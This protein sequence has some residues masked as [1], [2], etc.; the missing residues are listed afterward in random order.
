[1]L[2]DYGL[3]CQGA[4]KT[5]QIVWMV[6]LQE[7]P[8]EIFRYN[9]SSSIA[10]LAYGI[11]TVKNESILPEYDLNLTVL[12]TNCSS[13]QGIGVLV[14]L[15]MVQDIDVVIG[16]P[17]P[18]VVEPVGELMS[19][20]NV[21]VINWVSLQQTI[22]TK[23][24]LT[25]YIRTMTPV[26]TL[27]ELMT[28]F[29][30]DTGWK[31]YII[32]RE[33]N[34]EYD[35]LAEILESTL[36]SFNEIGFRVTQVHKL[37]EPTESGDDI[38]ATLNSIKHEGRIVFLVIDQPNLRN[39]M[40]RAHKL[41]MTN[42]D[43]QFLYTYGRTATMHKLEKYFMNDRMW[44]RNDEFDE[45]ARQAFENVL[46]FTLSQ[47]TEPESKWYGYAL[48]SYNHLY[49]KT[50][51][52]R[53]L[54]VPDEYAVYLYDAVYLYA[55]VLNQ[56]LTQ[57]RTSSGNDLTQT[58]FH[59]QIGFQGLTGSV[60]ISNSR[61]DRMPAFFVLDMDANGSFHVVT[62]LYYRSSSA[63]EL[64]MQ[65]DNT[66][67][68]WGN[69]RESS[70]LLANGTK[71][72]Y[73]PPD[74]PECGLLN[75]KCPPSPPIIA[76]Q[77]NSYEVTISVI[78]AAVLIL[79]FAAFFVYRWWRKEQDLKNTAWKIN[80]SDLRYVPKEDQ[81]GSQTGP[82]RRIHRLRSTS[83]IESVVSSS[84]RIMSLVRHHSDHHAHV[85]TNVAECQGVTVA[86]KK[87]RKKKVNIDRNFML[88]MKN[89]SS[90]KHMNVTAFIGVCTEPEKVCIVWEFCSKGSVQDVI[91]NENINLDTMFKLS[92]ANDICQ[93]LEYIHKSVIKY[94]GNLKS[95]NCVI[96]SRWVCKLTDF[97]LQ[98]LRH[99][100]ETA[101][102]LG[103]VVYYSRLFWTAP[104]KLRKILR[105]EPAEDSVAADIYSLGII[106]KELVCRNEPY[107]LETMTLSPKE[108]IKKV[109]L[110][111]STL[112]TY[113]PEITLV[114]NDT[115]NLVANTR[116][117]IKKCWA[118]KEEMRPPLKQ[119]IRT[120]NR[121]NPFKKA[122]MVDNMMAMMEKYTNNLEEIVAERTE[123]LQDEK[124]KTDALLYRMLPKKVADD[125][126]F[127]K[128][129]L[130]EAFDSVT[131]YLS[132]IVQFTNLAN[133]STPMEIVNLLN[134]LYTLFDES[135]NPYD[136]YK[137]ETIGDAYMV[138]SG[139]P[140]RNGS[141]HVREIASVAIR[142]LRNVLNFTIPHKPERQLQI[143]IGLHTG[144]VV[145]GVI[146]LVMPRYCLF[147]DTVNTA[148]RMESNGLPLKIHISEQTAHA[149][150]QFPQFEVENRG[151]MAIK[152]KGIMNTYWIT[153][154]KDSTT[155]GETDYY[156]V[157]T[158]SR[159]DADDVD[160]FGRE[161][162]GNSK[163][164]I[165][166]SGIEAERMSED[167]Y[168]VVSDDHVTVHDT[169][170]T[171][172]IHNDVKVALNSNGIVKSGL[173]ERINGA[174]A[175]HQVV[176]HVQ[177]FV[178][179][180]ETV[181]ED[182]EIDRTPEVKKMSVDC[183]ENTL[184]AIM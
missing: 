20:R 65:H 69:G 131:I 145:A 128:A 22:Q 126:K 54:P 86:V 43:Y 112:I 9:A 4:N 183:L 92:I 154:M 140:Q 78:C 135:I 156:R 31:N 114:L 55:K 73:F 167:T 102:Y 173:I 133:E 17:C 56:S 151:Q 40:L 100:R 117:L 68:R 51:M 85:L 177:D 83:S 127:G 48:S 12:D 62:Y 124:R 141:V 44:R 182:S 15:L 18:G 160:E 29:L 58:I 32:V 108:I 116:S 136:V 158:A 172:D 25:T 109:S 137:V 74:M 104:E 93:G 6:P 175:D 91:K 41:N 120:L 1:M 157:R 169:S 119:I 46:L 125:L 123:Q 76:S 33:I 132:D 118:E 176:S 63:G 138:V 16:P 168:E 184:I 77:S 36:G 165:A 45:I 122:S 174:I 61:K 88:L 38:D 121:I 103:D 113:R 159:L 24:S 90:M 96:D 95:S 98:K 10:A 67:I 99:I 152:G 163:I 146:G 79:V 27:G 34:K 178:D 30:Q 144:P 87:S 28:K 2:L 7:H 181:C 35:A 130:A 49:S 139:L 134:A 97:N 89:L 147:G 37:H 75:E 59:N 42:G 143:R 107:S 84:S 14:D 50:D 129:F 60:L 70:A 164:S 161:W 82:K 180:L 148:S 170:I 72:E 106:F 115:E 52:P 3:L 80:S 111:V 110:P 94:H 149:L 171:G 64:E 5:L 19:Y 11:E 71:I 8:K 162:H 101:D 66:P 179:T 105:N 81:R 150:K 13:K 153:G 53:P 39:V 142:I 21:P 155:V 57:N 47:R 166:D 23:D 26:Y